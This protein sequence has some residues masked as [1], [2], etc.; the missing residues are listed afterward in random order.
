MTAME[1]AFAFFGAITVLAVIVGLLDW[2]SRRKD[3][4][5][6]DLRS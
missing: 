5:Q 3:E 6:R 2:W 1:N 4:Q